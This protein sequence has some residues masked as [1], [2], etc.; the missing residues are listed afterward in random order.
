MTASEYIAGFE[1]VVLGTGMGG[2]TGG[3][4]AGAGVEV[5]TAGLTTT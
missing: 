2:T 5:M 4:D 1:Y 3:I